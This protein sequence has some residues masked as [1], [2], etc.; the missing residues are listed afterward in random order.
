MLL[1]LCLLNILLVTVLLSGG[2][3]A[4]VKVRRVSSDVSQALTDYFTPGAED[5]I[6]PFGQLVNQVAEITAQRLGITVQAAIRGAQGGQSRAIV[7]ALEGE[8][9]EE[10][11]ELGM[12][13]LLPKSLKK[14]PAAQVGLQ[15]L[16]NKIM[17]GKKS[18]GRNNGRSQGIEQQSFNL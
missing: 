6:S 3:Y 13:E 16:I 7:K 5:G 2:V 18:A 10:I 8:A 11:P 12:M 4:Y 9:A 15:L 14:S 1:I 17:A